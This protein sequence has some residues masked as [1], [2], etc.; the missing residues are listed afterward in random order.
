VRAGAFSEDVTAGRLPGR[1]EDGDVWLGP[2]DAA[3]VARIEQDEA[4]RYFEWRQPTPF[5]K[6]EE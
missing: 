6:V 1:D 5:V 2:L 3:A 4:G